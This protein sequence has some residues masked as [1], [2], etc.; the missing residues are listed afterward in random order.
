MKFIRLMLAEAGLR[1]WRLVGSI[2]GAGGAMALM[3]T[4]VNS[5]AD[6]KSDSTIDWW[7]FWLFALSAVAIVSFEQYAAN[8]TTEL[9]ERMLERTRLRIADLVRTSELDGLEQVGAV[10]IY[11]TIARETTIVSQSA[12]L[13]IYSLTS[14]VALVLAIAYIAWLSLLVFAVIGVLLAAWVY[15]YTFSQRDS[16]HALIAADTAQG[17]FFELMS[18]LLYGFKEVKLH[19]GRGDDLEKVHLAEAS[20]EAE[21]TQVI[22]GRRLNNGMVPSLAIFYVILGSAVFI[23]PPHLEDARLSMKVVYM[24][25]FLFTTVQTVSRTLP[26]LAKTN[27]ALDNLDH[28]EKNLLKAAKDR[29]STV[30]PPAGFSSILLDGVVYQHR[31]PDGSV[32]FTLGPCDLSIAPGETIFFV[33]GNGSGKSTLMRVLSG[34]YPLAAGAMLWDGDLVDEQSVDRYRNLFSAVYA[35]FHLFDRLYGMEDV[36]P[37][38]VRAL[39]QDVG[40]AD[41]VGYV[42]GRFSTVALSTGQRKR[43]AFVVALIED[44]PVY[45]LDE[46]SA[47]QDPGFRRRYYEEFLPSLKA[48]GKTLIVVSHDDRYFGLAD[49]VITMEHGRFERAAVAQ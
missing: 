7:Q 48:R 47:D 42:D 28:L 4:I 18:H 30:A 38:R 36:D 3:M 40:L 39:L 5:V 25:I 12:A 44:R 10:R 23:L 20:R 45:L 34:L 43:L 26:V 32:A 11:D 31:A 37:E 27:L 15:F 9:S 8:L 35:D 1:E 14:G 49:R 17:R 41:K 24:V 22:A 46:L 19:K 16:R 33:G 13:I 6:L 21:R 2:A 29:P